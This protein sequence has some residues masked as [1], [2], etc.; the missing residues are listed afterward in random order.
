[1]NTYWGACVMTVAALLAGCGGG[2]GSDGEAIVIVDGD[3]GNHG[4]VRYLDTYSYD[5]HRIAFYQDV[6]GKYEPETVSVWVFPDEASLLVAEHQLDGYSGQITI[7]TRVVV[8]EEYATES[9]MLAWLD[10]DL[11]GYGYMVSPESVTWIDHAVDVDALFY[12]D[13]YLYGDVFVNEYEV[14]YYVD[15]VSIPGEFVLYEF[16]DYERVLEQFDL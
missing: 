8:F 2:S 1:M 15:S 10:H 16:S 6:S 13:S 5:A 7:Y 12:T 14:Q 11:A 9:E 3:G 4:H